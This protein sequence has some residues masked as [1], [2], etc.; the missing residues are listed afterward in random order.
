MTHSR[1]MARGFTL[2]ELMIT[3]VVATILLLVAVPS[4]EDIIVN[5]RLS[6]YAGRFT[7]SVQLARS[8]AIKRNTQVSVCVSSDGT[9]C[10]SGN[11]QQGWIVIAGTT[12]VYR[13]QAL[14]GGLHFTEAGGA[15]SLAF[16]PIGIGTTPA[17][18]T[19]CSASP[20][21]QKEQVLTIT[22]A[23]IV[24]TQTTATGSCP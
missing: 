13:E 4:F 8:E 19:L 20:L 7:S 9:S 2:L 18:L 12:V 21:G 24:R 14:P 1:L 17:T 5:N 15:T 22:A 23:G 6:A 3:L 16:Q 11:W 10:G